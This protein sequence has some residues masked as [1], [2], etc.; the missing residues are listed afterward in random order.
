MFPIYILKPIAETQWLVGPYLI[1][2]PLAHFGD[3]ITKK[4][5]AIIKTDVALARKNRPMG[6]RMSLVFRAICYQRKGHPKEIL[7]KAQDAVSKYPGAKSTFKLADGRVLY[8]IV[9]TVMF[10]EIDRKR[11]E[12]TV[13]FEV[14]TDLKPRGRMVIE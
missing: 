13:D 8:G 5:R 11:F 3:S 1:R 6:V 7:C 14:V 12:L 10:K 9:D 2:L 4:Q